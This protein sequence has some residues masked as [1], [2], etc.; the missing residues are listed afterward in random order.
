MRPTTND[1]GGMNMKMSTNAVMAGLFAGVFVLALSITG[2]EPG[3]PSMPSGPQDMPLSAPG[4]I[5]PETIDTS[6]CLTSSG[7]L[8]PNV[9]LV[10]QVNSSE[11]RFAP[12]SVSLPTPVALSICSVDT[13]G[14]TLY[15]KC[16]SIGPLPDLTFQKSAELELAYEDAGL[17]ELPIEDKAYNVFRQNAVTGGWDLET[18]AKVKNGKV[19]Y[20]VLR[21]GVYALTRDSVWFTTGTFAP[22]TGGN[23]DLL[24]SS[25]VAAPGSVT[26]TTEVSF[27]ITIAI[28]EGLPGATRRVFDFGPD[29][30]LFAPG[31]PVTLHVSFADA[32][33]AETSTPWMV[34]HVKDFNYTLYYFDPV[35]QTWVP[36]PT[37]VDVA[38]QE[39]IVTLAHFSRYAFGR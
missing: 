10:L 32:G 15:P 8:I 39:F 16:Q 12:H 7:I 30:L 20:S 11:V 24:A 33:I 38:K 21:T 29:G 14:T 18:H 19:K 22:G 5:A 3:A 2:C 6:D 31:A 25:L 28:P 34:T 36:Q 1:P 23:V 27:G 17:P 35:K 13:A 4:S 26:I 9:P 37:V